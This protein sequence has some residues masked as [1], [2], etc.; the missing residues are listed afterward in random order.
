MFVGFLVWLEY[1]DVLTLL[2]L[3]LPYLVVVAVVLSNWYMVES[4][5]P[6]DRKDTHGEQLDPGIRI[7]CFHKSSIKTRYCGSC[8]KHVYGLDHVSF[9]LSFF[10]R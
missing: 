1:S 5:D 2:T 6:V 3:L 9:V 7:V 4:V 8:R 10:S